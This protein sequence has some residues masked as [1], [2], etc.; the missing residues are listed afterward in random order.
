MFYSDTQDS[1]RTFSALYPDLSSGS[2]LGEFKWDNR[3]FIFLTF[4]HRKI[5]NL[6]SYVG[7]SNQKK[8]RQK[9]NK[10]LSKFAN[11]SSARK[12]EGPSPDWFWHLI[13]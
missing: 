11:D 7:K 6:S 12:H 13:G 3:F 5:Q 2:A 8:I 4:L 1:A 9:A 10:I